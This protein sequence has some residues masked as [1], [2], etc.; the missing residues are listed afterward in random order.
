MD[1]QET[2][3]EDVNWIH[4]A[5]DRDQWLALVNVVMKLRAPGNFFLTIWAII[6]LSR[7]TSSHVISS[8]G[9]EI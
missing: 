2:G 7:K 3:Y 9:P 6:S 1:L 8:F 4:L 5:Y